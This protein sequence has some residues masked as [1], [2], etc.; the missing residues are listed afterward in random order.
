MTDTAILNHIVCE[1]GRTIEIIVRKKPKLPT[2]PL[3]AIPHDS[4]ENAQQEKT[5]M[6]ESPNASALTIEDIKQRIRRRIDEALIDFPPGGIGDHSTLKSLGI[7]SLTSLELV[8]QIE[9]D[10]SVSIP[11]GSLG[12]SSTLDDM[13]HAVSLILSLRRNKN[14][15]TSADLSKKESSR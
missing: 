7:D 14:P 8:M 11:D 12:L 1:C 5:S 2:A 15:D 4:S 9:E 6:T 10:F 3:G 13:A